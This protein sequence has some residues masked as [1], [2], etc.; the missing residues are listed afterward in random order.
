MSALE[1]KESNITEPNPNTSKQSFKK[2]TFK[3]RHDANSIY[4]EFH[5]LKFKDLIYLQNYLFMLQI[6]QNKPL[7]ASFLGLKYCGESHNYTTRSAAK[8]VLH[9]PTNRTDR[10]GKQSAKYICTLD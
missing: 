2:T 1:S 3:K 4:K 8:K 7:A 9:I 6:E 5:I 10:Y